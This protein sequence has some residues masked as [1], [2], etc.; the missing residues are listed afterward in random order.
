MPALSIE[1]LIFFAMV[2][3]AA[4][5]VAIII[6]AIRRRAGQEIGRAHV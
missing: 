2:L 6:S 5:Y 1:F 3:E 4:V